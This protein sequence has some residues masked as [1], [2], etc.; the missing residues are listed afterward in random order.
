[1]TTPSDPNDPYRPA[2]GEGSSSEPGAGGSGYDAPPAGPGPDPVVPAYGGTG[3]GA[4][5]S[6]PGNYPPPGYPATG[7]AGDGAGPPQNGLGVAAL[8]VGICAFIFGVIFFPLG[9]VLGLVGIGLGIAARKKARR[10]E[11]TNGG[12]ALTGLILSV[13]GLLI[14]IAIGFFVGSIFNEVKDCT[15]PGLSQAE[16]EQCIRDKLE[17]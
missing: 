6:A 13:V 4:P 3:Y 17:N 5:P 7:Y 16:Q 8:V 2:T 15:D 11:A 9:F 1:M 12:A 10:G 14:A